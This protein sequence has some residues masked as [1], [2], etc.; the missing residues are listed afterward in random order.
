M[1]HGSPAFPAK[2]AARIFGLDFLRAAAILSVLCAHLFAVLYPHV[3]W[4]GILGH[5]GFFGVELF[6]VLSGFLIGQILIRI[7]PE[8]A[9]GTELPAFYLRRWF[10]TLPLFWLLVVANLALDHWQHGAPFAASAPLGHAFFLR[11]FTTLRLLILPES[12]SLAVEEWFYLL[13]PAALWLGLRWVRRFDA[14]FI[15]IALGFYLLS[16]IAR[17]VAAPQPAMT[18]EWLRV[19]VIYRF[20][21]IMIGMLAAWFAARFSAA[22]RRIAWPALIAGIFLVTGMYANLWR[23]AGS[24]VT[25]GP[26]DFFAR[27]W[28]FNLLSLGF[29]LLLPIASAWR[30]A[31]NPLAG[32]IRRIALWSYAIYLVQYPFS[33]L[34][35]P[36]LYQD[37]AASAAH[38][39]AIFFIQLGGTIAISAVLHH[40]YEAPCTRLREWVVPKLMRLVSK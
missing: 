24:W 17:I 12:W 18:W 20:D 1:S 13:F 19:V 30:A 16:T 8:L 21:A 6:F 7:G 14:V 33:R 26:D 2:P 31:E 36:Y 4:L 35:L 15:V 29:A 5:G 37:S 34:V 10:R 25:N 32:A 3:W 22:W 23:L 39:W 38:A 11:N 28:R 9:D 40:A 27:T